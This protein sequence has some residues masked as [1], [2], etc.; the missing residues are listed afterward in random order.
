MAETNF[1]RTV[2][3]GGYDKHDVYNRLET[4]NKRIAELESMLSETKMQLDAYTGGSDIA[5]AYDAAMSEERTKLAEAQAKNENYMV[6]VADY[7]EQLKNKENEIQTLQL[8]ATK[9]SEGLAD[10]NA[11]INAMKSGDE[12]VA[13]SSVFIEAQKT[14]TNLKTA[15]Q[16][17][18]DSIKED[19]QSLAVDIVNEA[20]DEAARIIYEAEKNAAIKTTEAQNSIEQMNVATDNMRVTMLEDITKFSAELA[21]I[22]NIIDSFT[23]NGTAA[24][25]NATE[26]LESTE[27]TLKAGGV[28]QF[29]QPKTFTPELPKEPKP[30]VKHEAK[31]AVNQE[32]DKKK[33]DALASL[34]ERANAIGSG[35]NN[36]AG[37]PA[38]KGKGGGVNLAELKKRAD[39][40]KNKK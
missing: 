4:L 39:A 5:A 35:Q 1:M 3:N 13:L 37:Q 14:S 11:Q 27:N 9:L 31:S 34:K 19:A 8:T 28:P 38:N 32:A 10:A 36:T 2:I 26:M 12:A 7:E 22:K 30:T 24:L 40:L 25:V 21:G 23:E 17:E 15:A 6:M 16:K 18:A 33:N 20:N 29:R